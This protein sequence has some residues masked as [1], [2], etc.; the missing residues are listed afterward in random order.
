LLE[1]LLAEPNG[2]VEGACAVV[3]EHDDGL[4]W[5]EFLV[6]AGGDVAHGHQQGIFDVG[7]A[8]L[9]WLADVE[10]DRFGI[11]GEK[12]ARS[13]FGGE[14]GLRILALSSLADRRAKVLPSSKGAVTVG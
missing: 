6:G 9:P 2:D 12:L 5:I 13:D 1:A 14:H 4:V 10:E 3:A 11:E 8:E 7:G